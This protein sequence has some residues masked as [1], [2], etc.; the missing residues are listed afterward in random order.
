MLRR[1][2]K[3]LVGLIGDVSGSETPSDAEK[4]HE[5]VL[6]SEAQQ[7][8]VSKI[9]S[10]DLKMPDTGEHDDFFASEE[11]RMKKNAP[12]AKKITNKTVDDSEWD[13]FR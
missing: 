9:K 1:N 8:V 12:E 13:D 7:N 2:V 6:L 11:A 3:L 5:P 10:P 4:K